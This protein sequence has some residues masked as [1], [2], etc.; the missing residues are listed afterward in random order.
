MIFLLIFLISFILTIFSTPYLIE[1]LT[2][3]GIVDIPNKR[4]IHKGTI[5]RMGGLVIFS[6]FSIV[7]FSFYGDLNNIR[8]VIIGYLFIVFCGIVDDMIG[9]K[10][11]VKVVLQTISVIFLMSF[12]LPKYNTM[13]MFGVN[14]PYGLSLPILFLFML[15]T[16]NSINL[17]DGM[18]GLVSG[19]SLLVLIFISAVASISNN[20]FV[21][22]A[23][24]ILAGSVLGFLKYNAFPARIFLGD[25]GSLFLGFSLVFLTLSLSIN[26][27]NKH[28]D[29]TF[30]IFILA[31]PIIDTLKVIFHRLFDK[32]NPFLPDNNHL[33]H[34]I[35]HNNVKHKTTV[36]TIQFISL[37]FL[38]LA[39]FYYKGNSVVITL[40]F[41]VMV[42]LL[43]S[44]KKILATVSVFNKFKNDAKS[45]FVFPISYNN[46]YK[47][48]FLYI[49]TFFILLLF[50][51]AI[52]THNSFSDLELK[53]LLGFGFAILGMAIWHNRKSHIINEIYFFFNAAI[54]FILNIVEVNKIILPVHLS[55]LQDKTVFMLFF[56]LI[57][58]FIITFLLTKD[59]F[60]P[61][62]KI[63]LNG[64]DLTL[65]VIISFL[66]IIKSTWS[67]KEA[68]FLSESLFLGYVC[69]LWFKI[70]SVLYPKSS[71]YIF[72][73]S[74]VFPIS[75]L[76]FF[77]IN[78]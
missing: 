65:I 13:F 37:A 18:D 40:I 38:T 41:F 22:M 74:F 14:I 29:L 53:F 66:F 10:W 34:I 71:K 23:S 61:K 26:S 58:V 5:P 27:T 36:F 17:M 62:A 60:L 2:K 31:V 63:F 19:F 28:L 64:L 77:I 76:V 43:L 59:R 45:N 73:S 20:Y 46:I 24:I 11:Y 70:L 51:L 56:G 4:K 67:F 72:Y 52:N 9:L 32:K 69:Y 47:K 57:S 48:S 21:F 54:F 49:S 16:I 25:T 12:I 75:M 15:G 35:F 6:V 44:V 78:Q 33:H 1:L 42:I 50:I 68:D 3:N 30:P 55:L 8:F 7:L 39:I